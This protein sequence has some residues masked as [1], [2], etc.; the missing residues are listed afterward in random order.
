MRASRREH[1]RRRGARRH[2][3]R[4]VS[5]RPL[6]GNKA[7]AEGTP[8][9]AGRR[10]V[11]AQRR[12][13]RFGALGRAR[14]AMFCARVRCAEV[15]PRSADLASSESIDWEPVDRCERWVAARVDQTMRTE[16]A[17]ARCS[18]LHSEQLPAPRNTLELVLTAICEIDARA[19]HEVLDGLGHQDLSGRC[20]GSHARSD[21]DGQPSEVVTADLA[22]TGVEADA[23]VDPEFPGRL[24]DRLCAANGASRAVEG[25]KEAVPAGFDLSTTMP[26]ELL[27]HGSVVA[28]EQRPPTVVAQ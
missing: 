13:C 17:V 22:L 19:D 12:M 3:T 14:L 1:V 11:V 20:Q 8:W 15:E 6:G 27:A 7:V 23:Q 24:D 10:S 28:V 21:V 4:S 25:C 2:G 5:G 18:T 9:R 26:P 16:P